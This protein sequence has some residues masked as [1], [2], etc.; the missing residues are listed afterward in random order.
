[1][2]K[3]IIVF[4]LISMCLSMT[5]C[6]SSNANQEADQIVA[7]TLEEISESEFNS[8]LLKKGVLI[9]KEFITIG[10]AEMK[11]TGGYD[12]PIDIEI[13]TLTNIETNETYQCLRLSFK[14]LV[15]RDF[16][17][18]AVALD[19]DEVDS[20]ITALKYMKDQIENKTLK[21]YTEL[22]FETHGNARFTLT[23]SSPKDM[24]FVAQNSDGIMFWD[25]STIS[26]LIEELTA[27][28]SK[29]EK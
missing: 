29:L 7:T 2:N 26:E 8:F 20:A 22:V 1:L 14:V 13:A 23:Y 5:A 10:T 6:S 12:H 4:L 25:A 28:K 18:T 15:S 17:E 16:V 19:A 21:N 24:S 9:A 11:S 3:I 27:A